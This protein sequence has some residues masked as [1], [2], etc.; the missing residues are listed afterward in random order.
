[1]RHL[2]DTVEI[3]LIPLLSGHDEDIGVGGDITTHINIGWIQIIH[4]I[5][6]ELIGIEFVCQLLG[7]IGPETTLLLFQRDIARLFHHTHR[8]LHLHLRQE[9]TRQFHLHGLG[10]VKPESYSAIRMNLGRHDVITTKE[11]LLRPHIHG[12]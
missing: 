11:G 8:A 4:A 3:T 7:S 5:H 10:C 9:I 1:M 12:Q 2:I 6:T